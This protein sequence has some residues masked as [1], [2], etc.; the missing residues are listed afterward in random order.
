MEV[1]SNIL[2]VNLGKTLKILNIA[3]VSFSF[4][5]LLVRIPEMKILSKRVCILEKTILTI[6][7]FK[8]LSKFMLSP[9]IN[10]SASFSRF[11]LALTVIKLLHCHPIGKKVSIF[12]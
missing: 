10:E 3:D 11:S 6:L 12:F 9:I 1:V 8:I 2:D 5:P 7:I 4:F